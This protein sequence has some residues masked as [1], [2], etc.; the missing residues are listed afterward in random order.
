MLLL[1]FFMLLF[2]GLGLI[3]VVGAGVLAGA[4]ISRVP[5]FLDAVLNYKGKNC[6]C[7]FPFGPHV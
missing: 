2:V 5:N 3:W 4:V 1:V 6:A 7:H